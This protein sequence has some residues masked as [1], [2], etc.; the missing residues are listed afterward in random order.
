MDGLGECPFPTL[1]TVLQQ[2]GQMVDREVLH[3]TWASW[4][5]NGPKRPH[6]TSNIQ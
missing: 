3:R 4:A 2:P 5:G 6:P 1:H